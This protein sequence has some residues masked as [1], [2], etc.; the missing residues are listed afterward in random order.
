MIKWHCISA[1]ISMYQ[2]QNTER[3]VSSTYLGATDISGSH[4]SSRQSI[5]I[6]HLESAGQRTHRIGQDLV[7][8]LS[9]GG[10]AQSLGAMLGEVDLCQHTDHKSNGLAC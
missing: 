5:L 3:S 7:G 9:G 2:Q 10:E 4:L 8:E 6:G 1:L